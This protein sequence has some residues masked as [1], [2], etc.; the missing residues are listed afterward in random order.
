MNPIGSHYSRLSYPTA[1]V[2]FTL[3]HALSV[4]MTIIFDDYKWSLL[5]HTV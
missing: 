4:A 3:S 1:A 5:R 2:I